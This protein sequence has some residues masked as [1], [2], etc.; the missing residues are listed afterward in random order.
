M[1][2]EQILTALFFLLVAV[3]FYLFYRIIIPFFVPICWAAVFAIMLAPLYNKILA[4]TK[5][6]ALSSL[7][8]CALVLALIAGPITYLFLALV[9]QA[10]EAVAK[11]NALYNSGELRRYLDFGVPGLDFIYDKLSPYFDLSK[12]NLNDIAKDAVD[13]ISSLVLNQTS[14]LITNATKV[15]L[16]FVLMI[17]TTYYFF[18]EGPLVV[19]KVGR[20]L[21][22]SAEKTSAMVSELRDVVI[23]TMYSG[24]LVA[25]LQGAV[26]GILFWSVGID[27]PIFWGAI[28]AF[29]SIL[30]FI[31]SFL[32]YV[33]TGIILIISGS[34]VKGVVVLAVG[35]L[36]ISQIDNFVRPFLMAGKTALHPLLLFF[37]VGGG[38]AT[39]GLVGIVLGPLIAALFMTII[40]VIDQKL[41]NEPSVSV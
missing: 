38:I 19:N 14:W 13:R 39:F 7:L 10:S 1:R 41:H 34:V 25:L 35:S 30:P 40:D 28:M 24:V 32:I 16:Q 18:K 12:V 33:P 6:P 17:F 11:V 3:S 5:R 15:I 4:R 21:P 27:S 29:L 8:M 26:G 31:G 20:L 36:V 9:D 23:A 37:A 22:L 2:R